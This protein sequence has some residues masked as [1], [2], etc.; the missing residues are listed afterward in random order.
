MSFAKYLTAPAVLL[1][2][3]LFAVPVGAVP[4]IQT[5]HTANGA[6][7]LFVEAPELPMLNVRL[8]FNAGSAREDRPGVATLTN[9]MLSQGAGAWNAD[10]IAERLEA[11]GSD[12]E[13]GSLRDMA[14]VSLRTL[15]RAPALDT[16]LGTLT[17]L[18]GDPTFPGPDLERLRKN[19]LVALG[20]DEQEP[21]TVGSKAL[22]QALYDTHP[23]AHD[24][25]GTKESV[26]AITRAELINHF[27]RYYVAKNTVVALVGAVDRAQAE[28]IA[29]QVTSGLA[30][31][32]SVPPLAPV[33]ELSQ[34]RMERL[35][36]PSTQTHVY[37]G[38]PGISR[39]D[40]DYFPLY[41][42]NH[43]LGGNGLVSLLSEEV[44]EKRG[45]SYSVYSYFLPM[46]QRGPFLMG[47]QTKNRQTEQALDVLMQTLRRFLQEG[48]TE[49]ELRDAKQNLTGG[50]PLQIASN[51]KIVEQLALIGFYGLPLDYLATFNAKVEAVTATQVRE[52]FQRRLKPD[53][54]V[55]IVVGPT[56]NANTRGG[57]E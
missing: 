38:Q 24:P 4:N 26:T 1:S 15:I 35:D 36:F 28:R 46:Q 55:T 45:L 2:S 33:M 25:T 42:G 39:T 18:L 29:D 13:V 23:Y 37:V 34:G 40:P 49:A 27:R 9:A 3:L 10:Q 47:L 53:R 14:W 16:S 51:A 17:T 43:V 12:L 21:R 8:V 52:A 6:Q 31:G 44:R 50:F 7:V 19:T 5:W 30:K 57:A 48:P 41:V 20:Q 11:V 56:Q 32:E 54:F 22:Y